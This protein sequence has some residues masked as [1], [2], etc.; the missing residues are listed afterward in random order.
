[1]KETYRL[2]EAATGL[3]ELDSVRRSCDSFGRVAIVL[4]AWVGFFC[5][6]KLGYF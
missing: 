3:Q 4:Y 2:G 6:E 5:R 1:M